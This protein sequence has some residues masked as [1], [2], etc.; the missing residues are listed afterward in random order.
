MGVSTVRGIPGIKRSGVSATGSAED[1]YSP[2]LD[3]IV[4]GT[5]IDLDATI[6]ESYVSGTLWQSLAKPA[7]GGVAADY[8]FTTGDGSTAT[9]FPSLTGSGSAAYFA[10]DGGDYFSFGS[11]TALI[12]NL[13]KTTGGQNFWFAAAGLWQ[14]GA[15][16]LIFD[17]KSSGTTVGI[18]FGINADGTLLLSQRG[19]SASASLSSTGLSVTDDA[20]QV[21]V[22]THS[23]ADNL[24][25]F[26]IN[27]TPLG[28]TAHTFN[29]TTAN[30][31]GGTKLSAFTNSLSNKFTSGTGL[32]SFAM[33]STF[34][35]N[36]EELLIRKLYEKRHSRSY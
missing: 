28:D 11:N 18:S 22:C 26:W 17:T 7:G 33:G 8:A 34:I 13:H 10:F 29:T 3:G 23:H 24:T 21:L 20:N 2:Y 35:G 36:A 15:L 27:G 32:Y 30:A 19:D 16:Q 4:R 9:T 5:V 1:V 31:S 14:T 6:P 12:N 25:N